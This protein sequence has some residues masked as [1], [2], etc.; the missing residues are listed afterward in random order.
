MQPACKKTFSSHPYTPALWKHIKHS[1]RQLLYIVLGT[2]HSLREVICLLLPV[3]HSNSCR[4]PQWFN[5]SS[6]GHARRCQHHAGSTYFCWLHPPSPASV[7][8]APCQGRGC[9]GR[10]SKISL[11]PHFT[12]PNIT[13]QMRPPF[14]LVNQEPFPPHH[15]S[16]R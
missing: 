5:G 6:A 15:A 8:G 4:Q 16:A 12:H 14:A 11:N 9:E 2:T 3:M 1:S 7:R 13:T 10:H